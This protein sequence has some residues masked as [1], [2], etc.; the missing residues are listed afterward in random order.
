MSA[1]KLKIAFIVPGSGDS[2]YC[3][4]C[5]R[6]SL[7]ANA[8]KRA[9]H[10]IV[11]MPLY[12]PLRDRSFPADSPLFFP[13]TSLYLAQK[14]FRTKSM[15]RWMDRMLNSDFSLNMAASFSGT[16]SSEGLENMTLSMIQ[17]EDTVFQQQ[18]YTLIHWLKEQEQPDIIHLSSS[19]IIGIAKA[20]R[21]TLPDIPIVCSLQDEEVWID[22][23]KDTDA[24]TAWQGIAYQSRYIDRFVTSSHYY[25]EYI[26]NRLPQI[27]GVEVVYPGVDTTKYASG[28]Y[29]EAPTLGFFYRMNEL[30]GLGILTEAFVKLKKTDSIKNLRLRIGGGYTSTDRKFIK[31][32][33]R[34]LSPYVEDVD[35]LDT[36]SLQEHAAFYK[37]ISAICV[38]ITFDEGVGLYLCEAFAAGRRTGYRLLSRNHWRC[39]RTLYTQLRPGL[40]HCH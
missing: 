33:R 20:I 37:S 26:E 32:I 2:F 13:A 22:A 25:K 27:K 29:P 6:D 19:L 23:L 36:Y 7:H 24:Q 3:G 11:V 5:F 12:L 4:N 17:G 40:S 38:P 10:E 1:T 30:N 21:Q 35:W 15:P 9:G 28:Q 16:T 39:R 34:L 31:Q 18:V 8:L 14:Y